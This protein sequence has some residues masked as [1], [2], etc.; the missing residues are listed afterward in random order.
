MADSPSRKRAWRNAPKPAPA[1]PP[2]EAAW[3]SP[4]GPARQEL[5]WWKSR[6]VQFG[7]V[8]AAVLGVAVG[9][10]IVA[11]M[12]KPLKPFSFVAVYA[13]YSNNLFVPP[14]IAGRNAADDLFRLAEELKWS[15][16][17]PV[18]MT[19][20]SRFEDVVKE[21]FQNTPEKVV[22]FLTAH[23]VARFQNGG[24]V[25]YLV[26]QD[27]DLHSE[28][29]L[30][31]L[32]RLLD[33]LAELPS[34]TPKLLMLD[35]TSVR[36]HWPLGELHNDFA[37][38]LE[39]RAGRIKEINNLVV[40]SSSDKDQSSWTSPEWGQ[41]YFAHFVLEG[42]K[43]AADQKSEK[44]DS[45]GR[46]DAL[47]LFHYVQNHVQRW[48]WQN[49]ERLQTP[50][51][52]GGEDEQRAKS[53]ELV[54][55]GDY[56]AKDTIPD[57]YEEKIKQGYEDLQTAWGKCQELR[58]ATPHPAAYAPQLW[59]RYLGVLLRAE[60]LWVSGDAEAAKKMLNDDLDDLQKKI[61]RSRFV[62]PELK[63]APLTLAMPDALG[64]PRDG[65]EIRPADIA[66]LWKLDAA[67]KGDKDKAI[68]ALEKWS[69]KER[70][71][72]QMS[73]A[74]LIDALLRKVVEDPKQGLDQGRWFLGLLDAEPP[75]CRSAEAHYL[76]ML[77]DNPE[78]WRS[79]GEA[80]WP[81][82]Q[83]SLHLRRVAEQAALGLKE[84]NAAARLPAYSEQV[85]PW[86]RNTIE[87][88]D[89]PRRVGQ[90]LLFASSAAEWE[91]A[92][93]LLNEEARP[94]YEK[95]QAIA[96]KIRRAL[97]VRDRLYAELP[98]YTHW[99]AE[100]GSEHEADVIKLWNDLHELR[101]LLEKPV[102][103]DAAL[104][105]L[106]ERQQRL[107]ES[108]KQMEGRLEESANKG[109]PNAQKRWHEI[110]AALAVPFLEPATRM[111]LIRDSRRISRELFEQSPKAGDAEI[112]NTEGGRTLAQASAL[113]QGR[114]ALAMLGP[115]DWEEYKTVKNALD[116]PEEGAWY[117]SAARAGQNIGRFLN[118]LPEM[119]DQQ[120]EEAAKKENL[121]DAAASLKLAA[122]YAR[123]I[124]GAA[125]SRMTWNP[126]DEQRRL[127]WH[128][129]LCWQAHRT[130]LDW[131]AELEQNPR[132]PAYF[133]RA[134]EIFLKDAEQLLM[135]KSA[136]ENA[137]G[138]NPRLKRIVEERERIRRSPEMAVKV[139]LSSAG[140]FQPGP[141]RLNLTDEPAGQERY[142]RFYG[143]DAQEVPGVPVMWVEVQPKGQSGLKVLAEQ[144]ERKKVQFDPKI[145][146]P[147]KIAADR[148][149]QRRSSG[150][151]RHVVHGFFR[152]HH[153]I[154]TTEV[155]MYR[156]PNLTLSLPLRHGG[157]NVAVQ[158]KE[159][160]YKLFGAEKTALS[161]VLD[162]S[163]SMAVHR[164][165][166][167]IS[168]FR[169]ATRAL[170]SVMEELPE[171]VTVSLRA[172]GA[173]E[174]DPDGSL[175]EKD[176]MKLVWGPDKWNP[177]RV[178]EFMSKVVPLTPQYF[179]PLLRSIRRASRDFPRRDFAARTV[180][181]ITDGGD[182]EFIDKNKDTDLKE[183]SGEQTIS[184]YL[185]Y[186][187]KEF[188]DIGIHLIVIGF[189]VKEKELG[190]IN[191]LKSYKEFKKA[192]R[193]LGGVY[194]DAENPEKLRDLLR[195]S[196]LRLYFRVDP[197]FGSSFSG[198]D[199]PGG[200][201]T[202]SGLGE[203]PYYV[204][205][206]RGHYRVRVPSTKN[207]DQLIG[208]ESG[209]AT[210]L[211]LVNDPESGKPAF[212]RCL[213]A[214]SR[215]AE[216]HGRV[217]TAG[218]VDGWLLA[219]WQNHQSR[220][221]FRLHLLA[222]LEKD[223]GIAQRR[224]LL[225]QVRPEWCWFEV[226]A[227]GGKAA[228]PP[229][230]V[231]RVSNYPA[232]AWGLE[233]PIW[234]PWG[235]PVVLKAWWR[236]KLPKPLGTL[237]KGTDFQSPFEPKLVNYAWPA[238][239]PP[240]TVKLESIAI[241]THRLPAVE[242]GDEKEAECLAVRLSYPATMGPFFV[243]WPGWEHG[244]QHRFYPEAG[245]YTV[246]FWSEGES[247][248]EIAEKELKLLQ[249]YSVERLKEGALRVEGLK[250]GAPNEVWERPTP[251]PPVRHSRR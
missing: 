89:Q 141:A 117:N 227:A 185:K 116:N 24:L 105:Q 192:M 50:V 91:K 54:N 33:A 101:R 142:Y 183:E 57:A 115:D 190:T 84:D 100:L 166:D 104:A 199:A 155:R 96:V 187:M 165:N 29:A 15:R 231:H 80:N 241:E 70:Q 121:E 156:E 200:P 193:D 236:A 112:P 207:L 189:D 25:P 11:L 243:N 94:R 137:A 17:A 160:L 111:N 162:C 238:D 85:L 19:L 223:D 249:L 130:F 235:A 26:R 135:G 248:T 233:V 52:F 218:P 202:Q 78:M 232:P 150:S 143:P 28:A 46:V 215:L 69:G 9:L 154:L 76:M 222:T 153:P 177:E 131:W 174:F 167:P 124:E 36:A 71:R 205:R 2:V 149:A 23:G 56:H 245:K 158:T 90:D 186:L 102:A 132:M 163:G 173:K 172:F 92:K 86:I 4:Q 237:V 81:L 209:D 225:Q 139:A 95:A 213:Y 170:K 16:Q 219:V 224:E 31:S 48:V 123:M 203:I 212:R 43:G 226:P 128:N 120:S 106:D 58:R 125:L 65:M 8:A 195:R 77:A 37:R 179:T 211:D 55:C 159:S 129:L 146:H 1:S 246:L 93:K 122:H 228:P 152:G 83:Q 61:V 230:R 5:P 136:K 164:E 175:A 82:V 114:L 184:G 38:A 73:R 107:A 67:K 140:D 45:N 198:P 10:I 51:M 206:E 18:K 34:K 201:I 98:Y 145:S 119:A 109:S 74:V 239:V 7:F 217:P 44:G 63:S 210:L 66:D 99:I 72:R 171:G 41:T 214:K 14:N 134:G 13:D 178:N 127:H 133:Q 60:Q 182:S 208:I 39:S 247:I 64:L 244:Q 110:G 169:H 148:L 42:L 75:S 22:L 176:R 151:P 113:R 168:R 229:L 138:R 194:E 62:Q 161:I 12:W 220:E 30:Y 21:L 242:G 47:E 197:E 188:D 126:I 87:K 234:K 157:G 3:R 68:A 221:E 147:M 144:A 27:D 251:A 97:D 196:L 118:R 59:R 79:Q 250:V 49:R 6:R 40:I 216:L 108:F 32:D 35:V 204:P 88:A 180:V 53:L 103:D 240:G 20:D 181:V 191:E